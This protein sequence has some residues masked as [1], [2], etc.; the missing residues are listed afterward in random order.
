LY[1]RIPLEFYGFCS[2]NSSNE[3]TNLVKGSNTPSL[4][5]EELQEAET[6]D[7]YSLT[8]TS[9]N[10]TEVRKT[11]SLR[12]CGRDVD[13]LTIVIITVVAFSGIV[14]LALIIHILVGQPQVTPHSSVVSDDQVCST[15]GLKLLRLN[16]ITGTAQFTGVKKRVSAL[17]AAIATYLCLTVTRPD[18]VSIGGDCGLVVDHRH[19]VFSASGVQKQQISQTNNKLPPFPTIF[20]NGLCSSPASLGSATVPPPDAVESIGL[21]RLLSTLYQTHKKEGILP[22]KRLFSG[23]LDLAKTGFIISPALAKNV[24]ASNSNF[25]IM[26]Q[27]IWAN[28]SKPAGTKIYPPE[29]YIRLLKYI[30]NNGVDAMYDFAGSYGKPYVQVNP[31]WTSQ[32]FSVATSFLNQTDVLTKIRFGDY[33]IITPPSP[34]VS[35]VIVSSVLRSLTP[36]DLANQTGFYRQLT[37]LT[38]LTQATV[39]Y[40]TDSANN[41]VAAQ[42]WNRW[43]SWPYKTQTSADP[44]VYN[45]SSAIPLTDTN[46]GTN[47]VVVDEDYTY[48]VLSAT[49]GAPFGSGKVTSNGQILNNVLSMFSDA[50]VNAVGPNKQPWTTLSPTVVFHAKRKC[51][52]RFALSGNGGLP[53]S[54]AA[55]QVIANALVFEKACSAVDCLNLAT[56]IGKPRSH[57]YFNPKGASSVVVESTMSDDI[58]KT[59]IN[60]GHTVT[61][62]V[63]GDSISNILAAGKLRHEYVQSGDER[64]P[65]T[66]AQG[67]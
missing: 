37:E 62:L 9:D 50:G 35:G 41:S 54:S 53:A 63:K 18:L 46:G 22:W 19:N 57:V 11:A 33:W 43:I 23:A 64:N 56:A 20:I 13:G 39:S 42:I 61:R 25:K 29:D 59:L 47:I 45:A 16:T 31:S 6:I 1:R 3:K 60:A 30:A 40:A 14:T 36:A 28:Y 44:A 27:S 32:D 7:S 34:S 55:I 4:Q 8:A 17:D 52:P 5:N 48:I 49:L 24:L 66:V 67:F 51:G 58:V 12:C 65:N 2:M 38:K 21:P 26:N 15:I 10:S